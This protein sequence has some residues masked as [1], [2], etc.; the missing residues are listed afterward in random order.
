M[1]KE[2]GLAMQRALHEAEMRYQD[3]MKACK[4]IDALNATVERVRA[5]LAASPAGSAEFFDELWREA[6]KEALGDE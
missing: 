5:L 2:D 1:G 3:Y 4:K 6:I